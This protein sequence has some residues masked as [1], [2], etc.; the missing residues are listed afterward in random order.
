IPPAQQ[1]SV[2]YIAP[3]QL[4]SAAEL[5]VDADRVEYRALRPFDVG[6]SQAGQRLGQRPVGQRVGQTVAGVLGQSDCLRAEVRYQMG[7]AEREES[8]CQQA[9]PPGEE[10]GRSELLGK[11]DAVV[12]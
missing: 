2:G 6:G 9:L 12:E 7:F 8:C 3:G 1:A 10:G 11:G 4:R 5:L